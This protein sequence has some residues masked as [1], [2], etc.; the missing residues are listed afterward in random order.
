MGAWRT[1]PDGSRYGGFY[2]QDDVRDVVN[3]PAC[4]T[5]PSSPKRNASHP[6]A[7]LVAYPEFSCTG[8]SSAV[9]AVWGVFEDVYCPGR[10]ETF[11]FLQ[12]VLDE[13]MA[14]FPSNVIHIGGDEV[15]KAHWKACV[16]CQRRMEAEDLKDERELQSYFIRRIGAYV[17]SK[18]REIM[19]WDE[20]LEGGLAPGATVQVWRDVEHTTTT[21]R[22]GN[23]VVASPSSHA[24]LNRSPAELPLARVFEY[25]P[26]PDG[27]PAAQAARVLGGEATFWSEGIN[28]AN[29]DAMAFP[30]IATRKP[31]SG[32]GV[33]ADFRPGSIASLSP[34][35]GLRCLWA[36]RSPCSR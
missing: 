13:V 6:T 17:E 24:Y 22:M 21:V 7:A 3:T 18:G 8:E 19:G 25:N 12:N 9:P 33:L 16:F 34:L 1:E 11:R 14:L 36:G 32:S 31:W 5:S 2:T 27:L 4:G 26:V 28:D 23:R 20:I 29:F 30:R 10:E 35:Q 15:P